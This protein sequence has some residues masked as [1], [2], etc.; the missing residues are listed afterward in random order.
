M[1]STSNESTLLGF[2]VSLLLIEPYPSLPSSCFDHIGTS[3]QSTSLPSTHL[4]S[5]L[6]P[7]LLLPNNNLVL[8]SSILSSLIFPPTTTTPH[9]IKNPLPKIESASE[10][11]ELYQQVLMILEIKVHPFLPPTAKPWKTIG[12]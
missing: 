10:R 3:S 8:I 4:D 12:V 11:M 9:K 1:A 5:L 6:P 7:L 2:L